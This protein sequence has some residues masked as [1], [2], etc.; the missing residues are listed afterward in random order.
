MGSLIYDPATA[1]SISF[2]GDTDSYT[3]SIDP[4]QTITVLVEPAS[5]LRPTVNLRDPGNVLLGSA[6]AAQAGAKVVL[7]T[8]PTTGGGTYTITVGGASGT[9]GG[10]TVSVTL[11][12]AL[13]EED[14]GGATNNTPATA[15]NLDATAVVLEAGEV[16]G[17]RLA[18]SG[19]IRPTTTQLING[20][21]E[22]GNFTG[23]TTATTNSPFIPW[24]VSQ[25]APEP[26]TPCRPTAP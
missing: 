14:L 12:A 11:N 5:N 20:S 15:Q 2:A 1:S 21:F 3:L 7:Q 10:Y 17:D 25:A 4:S 22:T 26:A 18:V 19:A 6:T 8:I 23:W 9:M 13:E 16:A 24:T